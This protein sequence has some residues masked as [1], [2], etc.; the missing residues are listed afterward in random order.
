M[1]IFLI[2]HPPRISE[3]KQRCPDKRSFSFVSVDVKQIEERPSSICPKK[4]IGFDQIPLRVLKICAI[5]LTPIFTK[6]DNNCI[7]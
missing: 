1:L 7:S 5:K 4:S 2:E 3:I 6:I